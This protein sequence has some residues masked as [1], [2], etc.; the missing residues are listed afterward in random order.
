MGADDEGKRPDL[1]LS[2]RVAFQN[3][4]F[5]HFR[6]FGCVRMADHDILSKRSVFCILIERNQ[7]IDSLHTAPLLADDR[8]AA[9]IR[10]LQDRFDVQCVA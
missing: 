9:V 3:F 1:N 4:L 6:F 5:C 10:Y 8:K 2:H 7:L